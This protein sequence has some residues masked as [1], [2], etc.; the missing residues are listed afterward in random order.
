[1]CM[2]VYVYMY[3]NGFI[4]QPTLT[5]TSTHLFMN[6]EKPAFRSLPR[7]FLFA[8]GRSARGTNYI[9]MVASG[10]PYGIEMASLP[11]ARWTVG[12]LITHLAQVNAG[13]RVFFDL[14]K[15]FVYFCLLFVIFVLV[16]F[17]S[18]L[19]VLFYLFFLFLILFL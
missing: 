2:Y 7:F 15:V 3:V 19:Q 1:M 12:L 13:V 6:S 18:V 10:F 4:Y 16:D 14:M 9:F 17:P 11:H 8:F 5:H